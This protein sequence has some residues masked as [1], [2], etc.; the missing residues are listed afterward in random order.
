M[1]IDSDIT[2]LAIGIGSLLILATG[3]GYL[4][5]RKYGK[6]SPVIRN[7][8]E[9]IRAWW[10]MILFFGLG[11]VAG[12]VATFSMFGVLSFLALREFITLSHPHRG[13]HRAL[14]W[15][16]FILTPLQYFWLWKGLYGMFSIFI[17]VYGFLWMPIRNV[18]AGKT[19]D[20]MSR[21]ARV[22]WGLMVTVYFIS[23]APAL[24]ILNIEGFEGQSV[25]LLLFL[26]VIAQTSDVLQYVWG[27]ALGRHKIAPELSPGKTVEGF[28][29]GVMSASLLGAGLWWM[30]PF[31][32]LQAFGYAVVICIM[33]FMG[34]LVMSAI[35][36]DRG[37]KDFGSL[38]EGHGGILDRMDSI[39]FSAPLFFHLV[40][41]FMT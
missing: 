21:T 39:C 12:E 10:I 37:V 19:E 22:Q 36:R 34:G 14:F 38:I 4:F 32:P 20:Y 30:T 25:K 2:Y 7:L 23:H 18:L 41:Y 29:G 26:V 16:F 27:K 6:E 35:K 5:A 17:P 15:A 31:T 1:I 28:V 13:D 9:R 24:M 33:G 40:R 11:L 3:I 8:N